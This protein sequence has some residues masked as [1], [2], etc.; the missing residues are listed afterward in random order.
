MKFGAPEF[1]WLCIFG[2]STIAAMSM[3]NVLKGLISGAIGLLIACIGLDPMTGA[4]RFTFGSYSM[5]QGI[6]VIPA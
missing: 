4:P 6:E 2:L 1:F 5:V 3:D